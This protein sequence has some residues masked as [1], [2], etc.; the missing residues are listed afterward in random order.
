MSTWREFR[1]PAPGCHKDS[2]A[3]ASDREEGLP[4]AASETGAA[5]DYI[6]CA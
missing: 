5:A 4:G 6:R 2:P 3:Q 1:L